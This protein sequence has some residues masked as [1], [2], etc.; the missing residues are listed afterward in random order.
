MRTLTSV[1]SAS[2]VTTNLEINITPV[3]QSTT[4]TFSNW[5]IQNLTPISY[6]IDFLGGFGKS[7]NYQVTLS[8][9]DG[10]T[11]WKDSFKSLIKAEVGLTVHANDDS[12]TPHIGV[13]QDITRFPR[14]PNLIQLQIFFS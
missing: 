1:E 12:F 13:V 14:D 2:L 3:D 8:R 4:Y 5:H 7:S 11:F 6:E 9:D 10:L